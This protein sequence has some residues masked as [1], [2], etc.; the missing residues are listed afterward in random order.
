MRVKLVH[1]ITEGHVAVEDDQLVEG[2]RVEAS[3]TALLMNLLQKLG[4]GEGVH[5]VDGGSAPEGGR[6]GR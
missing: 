2:T 1:R 5:C 3:R 4:N 6:H